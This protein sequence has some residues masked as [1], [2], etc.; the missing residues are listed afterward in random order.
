MTVQL[1]FAHCEGSYKETVRKH[2]HMSFEVFAA[3][4]MITGLQNVIPC[5]VYESTHCNIPEYMI[6]QPCW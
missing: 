5:T 3:V 4:L 6:H 2:S 1:H